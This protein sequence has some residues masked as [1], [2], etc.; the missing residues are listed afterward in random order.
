[1]T[2]KLEKLSSG[3]FRLRGVEI[4]PQLAEEIKRDICMIIAGIDYRISEATV[5]HLIADAPLLYTTGLISRGT[6]F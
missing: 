3:E 6:G 5:Q 2:T 4:L 1:L